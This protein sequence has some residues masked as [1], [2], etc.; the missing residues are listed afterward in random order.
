MALNLFPHLK[1]FKILHGSPGYEILEVIESLKTE[2][3]EKTFV[4]I[5]FQSGNFTHISRRDWDQFL[6]KGS[7]I[8][9][10]A[11]GFSAVESFID[12]DS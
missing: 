5:E 1:G 7:V 11:S 12:A 6:E 9:S 3:L 2:S 4:T 8:F 10:R